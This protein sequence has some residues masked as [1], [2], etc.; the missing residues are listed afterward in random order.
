ME[1][2]FNHPV[3]GRWQVGRHHPY[4]NL[5]EFLHLHCAI[6]RLAFLCCLIWFKCSSVI[7]NFH[8]TLRPEWQGYE[9]VGFQVDRGNKDA[10]H[11]MIPGILWPFDL[12]VAV[13]DYHLAQAELSDGGES[14]P[15]APEIDP[16]QEGTWSHIAR[17][18]SWRSTR[19]SIEILTTQNS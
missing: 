4:R 18:T 9:S 15:I 7:S 1:R 8:W 6:L 17:T 2:G 16:I 10:A 11:P 14:A 12:E 19:K 5:D 3:W 13:S